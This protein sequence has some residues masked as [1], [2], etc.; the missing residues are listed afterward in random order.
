M[1]ENA[2]G[3]LAF[4][5]NLSSAVI[6]DTV[7][8]FA[9]SDLT[10]TGKANCGTAGA[11]YV[12]TTSSLTIPAGSTS[13]VI[14][15]PVCNDTQFEPTEKL[16]VTLTS[17]T[18]NAVLGTA[19]ATGSLVND[20]PGGLNDSGA[21][22]C[23]NGVTNAACPAAGYPGQDA[24]SGRDV[25]PLTN[26]NADGRVGFSYALFVAGGGSGSCVL[27]N[28]TGL[29]WESKT[30]DGG[31]RDKLKFYTRAE[32]DAYVTTVNGLAL[33]GHSDWRLPTPQE[34]ASMVDSSRSAGALVDPSG[35]PEQQVSSYWS[36]T[37]A[38]ADTTA[39]WFLDFG[40]GLLSYQAKTGTAYVRLVRA[41]VTLPATRF[42]VNGDGSLNDNHTGLMW[43]VCDDGLTGATCAGG[44]A[45][46]YSWQGALQR[47]AA[48]DANPAGLGLG[49]DDWRLPNRDELASLLDYSR[50]N[51]AFDSV[52]FPGVA[53]DSHWT[54]TPDAGNAA[55]AWYV[56]LRDGYVAL[57]LQS[58]AK[59]LL[60]VRDQ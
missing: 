29:M 54:S 19:T 47:A 49:H 23:S 59:A 11:D 18:G 44:S 28:V 7:V 37:S 48:V 57:A 34:L 22:L 40:S 12:T 46:A 51:P 36:G 2:S 53:A 55:R 4:T 5:V 6:T 38:A 30:S 8:N 10:A 21:A 17:V 16:R 52:R 43:R 58:D 60:L 35:F 13:G 14:Q 33:C 45:Q 41:T 26:G 50:R 9:T 31:T 56:D 24:Q 3:S 27:D 32:A 1:L 15:I 42:M 25:D 20:D 39:A